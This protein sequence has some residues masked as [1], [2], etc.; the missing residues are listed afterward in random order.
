MD[1]IQKANTL[2]S[3]GDLDAARDLYQRIE[4]EARKTGKRVELAMALGGLGNIEADR[5]NYEN[6][7]AFYKE[8]LELNIHLDRKRGIAKQYGNLGI[9]YKIRGDHEKALDMFR[10]SAAM[11]LEEQD[12]EA[13]G[14]T[15]CGIPPRCNADRGRSACIAVVPSR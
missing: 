10:H 5:H 7:E 4:D 8:A 6:A 12:L 14:V 3:N 2:Y 15:Y 11:S 13:V 1:E 9:L